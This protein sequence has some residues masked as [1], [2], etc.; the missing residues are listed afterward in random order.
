MSGHLYF[1]HRFAFQSQEFRID[2]SGLFKEIYKAIANEN[3]LIQRDRT[4]FRNYD[5]GTATYRAQPLTEF[6]GIGNRCAE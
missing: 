5:I 4:N 2:L 3:V 1:S 6:F